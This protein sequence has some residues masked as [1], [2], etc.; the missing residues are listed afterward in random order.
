MYDKLVA[1]AARQLELEVSAEDW[2][3][4]NGESIDL[5]HREIARLKK[6]LQH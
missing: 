5:V 1:Y 2:N 6:R 4:T 3:C